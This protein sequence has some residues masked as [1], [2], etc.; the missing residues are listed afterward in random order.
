MEATKSPAA[1]MEGL[2]LNEG[3]IVSEKIDRPP[4][5]SGGCF[6]HSYRLTRED[7]RQAFLK[8]LDFTEALRAPEATRV[9][10]ALTEAY[11]FER[12]VLERC[13]ES[14]LTK[15]VLSIGA[16]SAVVDSASEIGTVHY[17]IFELAD[18]DIRDFV[19]V[20]G[21][22]SVA[23]AFRTLHHVAVGLQQIHSLDIAHQDLKPSNVLL[24]KGVSSKIADFG[25][26]ACMGMRSPLQEEAI[27]G[28]YVYAPP[29]FLF[30]YRVPDWRIQKFG[31]DIYQFGSL[32]AFLLT[33]TGMTPALLKNLPEQF[34][35]E[36]WGGTFRQVLPYLS[37]AYSD[38]LED[39]GGALQ[40]LYAD[41]LTAGDLG[42]LFAALEQLCQP[43]PEMRG[44]PRDRAR[45]T[46]T[47]MERY[48]SLFDRLAGRSEFQL[49]NRLS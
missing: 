3:W 40:G 2:K 38:A 42:D 27:P 6:S 4:G 49:K 23:F 45:G 33:G 34:Y 39:I 13:R 17:L 20:D 12:D 14:R 31:A 19:G 22:F 43:D 32:A 46:Q 11:N 10:Q 5:H 30:G 26:S 29:E 44:H 41:F 16:G 25:Q 7:G 35:P 18:G 24:F 21:E 48:I 9:L 36:N 8:A 28:D 37:A 1:R 15:V 47:S